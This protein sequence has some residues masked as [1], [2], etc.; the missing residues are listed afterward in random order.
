MKTIESVWVIKENVLEHDVY[1]NHGAFTS[2]EACEKY[3]KEHFDEDWIKEC[4]LYA[5]ELELHN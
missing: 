5:E 1:T 3:I 4:A 2:K